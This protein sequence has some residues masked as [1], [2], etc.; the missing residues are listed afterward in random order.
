LVYKYALS[1]HYF[2]QVQA[3]GGFGAGV[4][5]HVNLVNAQAGPLTF[6]YSVGIDTG[7]GIKDD[8]LTASF[9]GT[10]FT[11]G[12]KIGVSILNLSFEIDFGG[13]VIM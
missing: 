4:A 3:W 12:R 10:G 8:S 1:V 5:A 6:A 2:L 7:I 9:L 13:C 11:L